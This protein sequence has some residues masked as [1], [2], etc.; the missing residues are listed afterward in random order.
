MVAFIFINKGEIT[1]TKLLRII[2]LYLLV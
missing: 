2:S 1:R